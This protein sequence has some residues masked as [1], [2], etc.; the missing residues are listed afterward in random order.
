M[1][2]P[3]LAQWPGLGLSYDISM[4]IGIKGAALEVT[5]EVNSMDPLFWEENRKETNMLPI[6]SLHGLLILIKVSIENKGLLSSAMQNY[7]RCP[8]SRADKLK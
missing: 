6:C 7:S 8:G 2:L 5:P 3:V 4:D 1:L